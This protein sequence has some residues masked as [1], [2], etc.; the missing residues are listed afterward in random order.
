MSGSCRAAGRGWNLIPIPAAGTGGHRD[1]C[2]E[3]GAAVQSRPCKAGATHPIPFP[4]EHQTWYCAACPF[5]FPIPATLRADV[6]PCLLIPLPGEWV[7]P[8][9][10]SLALP[11]PAASDSSTCNSLSRKLHPSHFFNIL[12]FRALQALGSCSNYL[13]FGS[14]NHLGM[15]RSG[16]QASL[17]K[18]G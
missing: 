12:L 1:K 18:L 10:S 9:E 5:F 6:F 7:L 8:C 15:D 16:Y 3:M 4:S 2:W 14:W 13:S 17:D 11:Q